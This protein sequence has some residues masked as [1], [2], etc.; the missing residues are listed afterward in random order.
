DSSLR[1]A[2]GALAPAMPAWYPLE[3]DHNTD[4]TRALVGAGSGLTAGERA[5]VQI[6]A[7]P[8]APRRVTE[9]RRAA[10]PPRTR[11]PS[12]GGLLAPTPWRRGGMTL[13]TEVLTP[14]RSPTPR[15]GYWRAALSD[16]IRDHDARPALDKSLAPQWE[17]GIRY[18][19]AIQPGRG[20][21]PD[22]E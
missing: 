4:P 9:A 18:A 2:G 22:S 6:L 19:V 21:N 11:P 16:P 12:A 15:S 13:F 1:D 17:V 10:P 8:A 14:T 5:C 7:R 3:V 20:T